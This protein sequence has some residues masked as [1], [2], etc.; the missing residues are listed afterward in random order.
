MLRIPEFRNGGLS[1]TP[2]GA[3]ALPPHRV[4]AGSQAFS[5]GSSNAV[6]C[7]N[8]Y[9]ARVKRAC[10]GT[11]PLA[12]SARRLQNGQLVSTLSAAPVPGANLQSV[13]VLL[14]S[15]WAAVLPLMHINRLRG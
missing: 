14:S 2:G 13:N 9:D 11:A 8:L 1:D 12:V 15:A 10:L 3:A 4:G 5:L 7:L 6:F